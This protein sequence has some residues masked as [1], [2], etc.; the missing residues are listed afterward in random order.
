MLGLFSRA[1]SLE[2][3]TA[4]YK[5]HVPRAGGAL[6]YGV[7]AVKSLSILLAS[8]AFFCLFLWVLTD[9]CTVICQYVSSLILRRAPILRSSIFVLLT[10]S[11]LLL[12]VVLVMALLPL[13]LLFVL[14][15][16]L[17][18]YHYFVVFV[19]TN[20]CYFHHHHDR[21]HQL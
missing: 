16:F 9:S 18:C 5:R 19:V 7:L 8:A 14:Y 1:F 11:L 12:L 17:C 13:L 21:H 2:Y 15:C 20:Y 10:C 4:I 6:F 3:Y